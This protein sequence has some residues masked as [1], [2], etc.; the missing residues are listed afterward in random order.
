MKEE[1]TLKETVVNA[2][3]RYLSLKKGE[4]IKAEN[5]LNAYKN[6]NAEHQKNL[7]KYIFEKEDNIKKL[8]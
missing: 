8:D 2:K 1:C 5:A 7:L 6:L 4:L 3:I